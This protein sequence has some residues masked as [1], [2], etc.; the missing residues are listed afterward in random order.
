MAALRNPCFGRAR[1]SAGNVQYTPPPSSGD[2]VPLPEIDLS[3]DWVKQLRPSFVPLYQRVAKHRGS[4]AAL[5]EDLERAVAWATVG[6]LTLASTVS[7]GEPVG[8]SLNG[9]AHA[10][11]ATGWAWNTSWLIATQALR[12]S[13]VGPQFGADLQGRLQAAKDARAVADYEERG[14][15]RGEAPP[16]TTPA[17]L[18]ARLPSELEEMHLLDHFTAKEKKRKKI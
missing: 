15:P 1:V 4:S 3:E 2:A 14:K 18:V 10:P 6:E 8:L 16:P 7:T 13:L 17:E 11:L 12:E 9:P 5:A